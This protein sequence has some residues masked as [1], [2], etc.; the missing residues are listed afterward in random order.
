M[1]CRLPSALR[2]VYYPNETTPPASL[3]LPKILALN[4]LHANLENLRAK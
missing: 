4:L 3:V 2:I 1:Q